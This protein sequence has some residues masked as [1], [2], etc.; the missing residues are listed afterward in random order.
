LHGNNYVFPFLLFKNEQGEW[1]VK[2]NN[3]N[4]EHLEE[5]KQSFAELWHRITVGKD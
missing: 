5:N 4:Q 3:R 2:Q 1:D